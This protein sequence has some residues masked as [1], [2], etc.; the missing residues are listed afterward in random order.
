[1]RR[2][3]QQKDENINEVNQPYDE[4][5]ERAVLGSMLKDYDFIDL[6]A[7]QLTNE[8]F[9]LEKHQ[10]LFKALIEYRIKYSYFETID[11]TLFMNFIKEQNIQ[12]SAD[13]IEAFVLEG[14]DDIEIL[15]EVFKILHQ[16]RR[17]RKIIQLSKQ[18][19]HTKDINVAFSYLYENVAEETNVFKLYK[20]SEISEIK[21]DFLCKSYL[22]IAKNTLTLL[23]AHGGTG[24]TWLA[25]NIAVNIAIE[26][27]KVLY[28]T[29]EDQIGYLKNRLNILLERFYNSKRDI[30][31]ENIYFSDA[32]SAI[33][34]Y[35]FFLLEKENFD[36]LIL[37]PL[38]SFFMDFF[39]N[40]NDNVQARKFIS[41]LVR[42]SQRRKITTL[43]I[44]HNNKSKDAELRARGASAFLDSS[45]LAYEMLPIPKDKDKKK[46]ITYDIHTQRELIIIKDNFGASAFLG[47]FSKILTIKPTP[48]FPEFPEIEELEELKQNGSIRGVKWTK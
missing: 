12:M 30:V 25:L 46:K 48:Q 37:D 13:E 42:E 21:Q 20:L 5:A 31:N 3:I 28:W 23:T 44:H 41:M 38:L 9:Y 1:M 27:A 34:P 24:K 40:E 14:I 47:G 2:N 7:A 18:L 15:L 19:E 22:P 35:H 43:I 32:T 4:S 29:K 8:D 6:C 11:F 36:L 16:K 33:S 45:R 10:K 39:D 17:E 26:G